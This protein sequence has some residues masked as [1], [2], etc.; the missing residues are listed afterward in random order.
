M[1][2]KNRWMLA[3]ATLSVLPFL[4]FAGYS[5]MQLLQSKQQDLQN[6]MVERTQATANAVAE[7]LA[8][9]TGALRALA[10]SDAALQGNVPSMY[11]QARRVVQ[12]MPDISA[13]ALVGEDAQVIF[14]TLRPLDASPFPAGD[15]DSVRHIFE[16]GQ[17]AAS[18][19]FA[20]PIDAKVSI[21]SVGMPVVR[22]GKVVYVLRAIFR[23]SSLNALLAAQ[24]MP[25]DWTVGI[26]SRS[27][28]V[29]AR[30]HSP[31]KYVGQPPTGPV[32][33]ALASHNAGVFDAVTKEGI[34]VKSVIAPV[35]GWDWHAV[36]GVPQQ[37]FVEPLT[38]ATGF[39]VVL[40]AALLMLGVLCA[41]WINMVVRG[42]RRGDT[43]TGHSQQ[44][45]LALWP[46]SAALAIALVVGA[47]STWAA[48]TALQDIRALADR[49]QSVLEEARRIVQLESAYKDLELAQA[50]YLGTGDEDALPPYREAISRIALLTNALKSGLDGMGVQPP[51]WA[52]LGYYSSERLASASRQMEARRRGQAKEDTLAATGESDK[53]LM[54]KVHLQLASMGLQL[55]GEALRI[56][57]AIPQ[58]ECK[59]HQLQWLSQFTVGA[60]VLLSVSIWL[61]ERRR[62]QQ[63]LKQLEQ[64]NETLEERVDARTRELSVVNQRVKNFAQERETIIDN[65]RKRLSREVHDQIGQIFTGLKMIARTLHPGSLPADQEKAMLD[66]IE[67]GVRI[68]RRI[69]AE[70]RPPLLDD[71]GL[72]AALEHHLKSTFEPLGITVGLDFPENPGLNAQQRDQMFRIVQE[73]CT[74]IVRHANAQHVEVVGDLTPEALE[75]FV[76]D[77]GV[78]IAKTG[79]RADSLGIMGMQ[80]RASLS[81]ASLV[82]EPGESGGTVVKLV[83]PRNVLHAENLP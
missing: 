34:V 56:N 67:A 70:L 69:A 36:V 23:S 9:C 71:F 43:D 75:V 40:G 53:L 79:L 52:D 74:N 32:M 21:T 22:N 29:L 66:A 64:V 12:G 51:N 39:L 5:I 76:E 35:P 54:D 24:H 6:Q 77:D 44:R 46:S 3:A 42:R 41:F 13:I 61:N 10:N 62:R 30:S 83:Y 59:S 2:S 31:E 45:V 60:L 55:E 78:G 81:G 80:E 15:K 27:G 14:L 28:L 16:T 20:S 82:I 11:A 48:Q 17:P 50:R 65:E 73:A 72:R 57:E 18:E 38:Q 68:S 58:Q 26:L 47:V 63:T 37:R 1:R 49:R 25:S 19:P 8:V 33:E 4:L 7:R